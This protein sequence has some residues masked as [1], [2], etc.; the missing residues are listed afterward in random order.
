V[1]RYPVLNALAAILYISAVGSFMFYGSKIPGPNV[2]IIGPI[3]VLSLFTLSAA[4]MAY[5]FFFKPFELYFDG[6]KKEGVNLA[7]QSVACFG[8]I[9]LLLLVLLFSGITR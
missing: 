9:T 8:G 4:V 1:S 7:F 5:I 2:S 3:V 6:K